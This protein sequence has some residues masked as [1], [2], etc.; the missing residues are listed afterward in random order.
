MKYLTVQKT[1]GI[2]FLST[3]NVR[4][5]AAWATAVTLATRALQCYRY[6]AN[7]LIAPGKTIPFLGAS[8]LF[9]LELFEIYRETA[10]M[11][12]M[13]ELYP[14]ARKAAFQLAAAKPH[15]DKEQDQPVD[16]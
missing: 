8:A 2:I 3:M 4:R 14:S 7:G 9:V 15:A 1:R 16:A 13:K 10:N 5:A 11:T 12:L 6:H